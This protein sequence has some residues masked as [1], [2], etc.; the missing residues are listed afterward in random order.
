M[1]FYNTSVRNVTLYHYDDFEMNLM[2]IEYSEAL[3]KD[4]SQ[5]F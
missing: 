1:F 5:C 3:V 2:S 4:C